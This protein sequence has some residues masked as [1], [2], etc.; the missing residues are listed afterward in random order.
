MGTFVLSITQFDCSNFYSIRLESGNLP[1]VDS[2]IETRFQRRQTKDSIMKYDLAM[3]VKTIEVSKTQNQT[4]MGGERLSQGQKVEVQ[5]APPF[6][7]HT[8]V[9]PSSSPNSQISLSK[10]NN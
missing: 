2:D 6:S 8:I 1:Q 4:D 5:A 7:L 3:T 9:T 10:R